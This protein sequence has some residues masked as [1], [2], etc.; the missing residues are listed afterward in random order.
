M[1]TNAGQMRNMHYEFPKTIAYTR[2][3]MVVDQIQT[4]CHWSKKGIGYGIDSVVRTTGVLYSDYF[5]LEIHTRFEKNEES[6]T[7]L[8]VI[9]DIV[10]EKPCLL[11][12][13]IETETMSGTKKYYE[14]FER[15]LYTEKTCTSELL[16]GKSKVK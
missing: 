9:A 5:Y 11:K 6:K 8:I 12:S 15:E 7:R 3:K 14:V 16:V 10:W 1:K 2:H 13:R 4:K